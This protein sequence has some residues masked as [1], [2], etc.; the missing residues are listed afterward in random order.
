MN[1]FTPIFAEIT[2]SSIWEEPYHVRLLWLTMLARRQADH[3]VYADAYKL[4][5]WANITM[6]ETE[7]ALRILSQ[8]DERRKGQEHEGRRIQKV[9]GG[10]L[11]LNGQKYQDLMRMISE[12]VRKAR[13]AR[14]NRGKTL[15]HGKPLP[16]ETAY[17]QACRQGDPEQMRKLEANG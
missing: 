5:K 15:P 12:R 2:D 9:E 8:P 10:W 16:G 11:I 1:T 6:E 3:V 4:K 13:W 17:D 14:E 7:D